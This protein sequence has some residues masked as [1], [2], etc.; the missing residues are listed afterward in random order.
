MR[1]N[2]SWSP[3]GRAPR[4]LM[5]AVLRAI[6]ALGINACGTEIRERLENQTGEAIPAAKV[7]VALSRLE[8]QGFVTAQDEVMGS[9]AGRRGRPRRIY[10]LTAPGL[11]ALEAGVRLYGS[12]VAST[13]GGTDNAKTRSRVSKPAKLG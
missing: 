8:N 12:P 10:Q 4:G 1:L 7:Y 6:P 11:R 2:K 3:S 9:P 13:R 5:F